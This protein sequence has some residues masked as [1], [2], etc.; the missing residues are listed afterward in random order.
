MNSTE[1]RT[2]VAQLSQSFGDPRKPVDTAP[3]QRLHSE[4]RYGEMVS[5][6]ARHLALDLT[7]RVGLVN[8]GG[9]KDSLAWVDQQLYGHYGTRE[10]KRSSVT[11]YLRRAFLET[12]PFEAVVR[13]ISHELSHVVLDATINPLRREEKVVDLA[14]MH[15]GYRGLVRNYYDAVPTTAEATASPV[16]EWKVGYL[17]E[18]E[19]AYAQ[20]LMQT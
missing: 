7:I 13:A 3:L 5:S 4:R 17:T 12:A 9:K 18:E 16:Q 15:F 14:V 2:W 19:I 20:R 8:S 6:I 11:V 10:F 1:I